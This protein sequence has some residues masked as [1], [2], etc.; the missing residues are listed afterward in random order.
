ME[1]FWVNDILN[2]PENAYLQYENPATLWD[3]ATTA[4]STDVYNTPTAKCILFTMV[5][6]VFVMMTI[7]NIINARKLGDKEYNVFSRFFNNLKFIGIFL[8][9][10]IM[11]VWMCQNGGMVMRTT[12][13][14]LR[15]HLIVG[16][17]GAFE[18]IWGLII[19]AALPS[20]LFDG[21]AINEEEM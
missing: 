6:Q 8:F 9:I 7:F 12:P 18:L 13:L 16:A 15:Q 5:F 19:K 11:Q 1:E 4:N 3:L 10:I 14:T 20:H 21:L 2:K 17:F